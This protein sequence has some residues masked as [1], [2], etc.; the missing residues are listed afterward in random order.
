MFSFGVDITEL[1][2]RLRKAAQRG[3][4]LGPLLRSVGKEWKDEAREKIKSGDG[5]PPLAPATLEKRRHTGTSLVTKFG[6]LRK[7][8]ARRLDN[9]SKRIQGLLAHYEKRWLGA[10][11]LF[12]PRDVLDKVEALK[13]RLANINKQLVRAQ[14][15]EY[16]L[17]KTGKSVADRWEARGGGIRLGQRFI[18]AFFLKAERRGQD[19]GLLVANHIAWSGVHNDGGSV[20][21]GSV[22]PPA[23]FLVLT[24]QKLNHLATRLA[25]YLVE[26][27]Q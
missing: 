4:D 6:E 23:H 16:A 8:R 19:W 18:G 9:E 3:Y 1:E 7:G 24:P 10:G 27:L 25:S 12:V 22:I 2:D 20:G 17:R 14:E 11:T 5:M 21:H 26:P 15:S 13:K